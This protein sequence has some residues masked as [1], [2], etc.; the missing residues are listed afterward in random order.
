MPPTL[1]LSSALA[2]RS[3]AKAAPGV[4]LPAVKEHM[5][6]SYSAENDRRWDI[7]HPSEL[8]H[9]GTFCPRAVYLRITEGPIA[10]KGSDFKFVT[11]N[12]F[13]EGHAIHAKWQDRL[14][15]ATPL[16]GNWYCPICHKFSWNSLEPT[17]VG[18]WCGS[19]VEGKN[20]D[21]QW[22]YKEITLD[23]EDEALLVGHADGGAWTTLAEFKSVGTGSVRIEAPDI[24]EAAGGDLKKMWD[25]ITRPFKTHVNQVDI[26][27]WICQVRGLPFTSA[28]IIYESKWNQLVKNFTIEYS[29]RRSTRLVDQAKAIKYAV[30]NRAEPACRFP[31][32][33]ENCKPYN[34]RRE[35]P[36]VR[37][38]TARTIG[39][40][41]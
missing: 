40:K 8:S 6:G 39:G 38:R 27:L 1:K 26:Y 28:E 11:E 22:E 36:V 12:I 5:L 29:E 19:T 10:P 35:V 34:E 2:E 4:L 14:R 32:G 16:F 37:K 17:G 23:A 9:Q 13:D 3:K 30:D 7:V 20:Y 41:P 25:G 24:F 21:H 33:C 31:D 18:N 15:Q